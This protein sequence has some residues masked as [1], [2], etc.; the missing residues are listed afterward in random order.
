MADHPRV[1]EVTSLSNA[2]VKELRALH[3]RKGRRESG[4]FLAEGARTALEA[5]DN[6]RAPEILVYH[7]E[8]RERDVVRRLRKACLE[9]GGECLEVDDAVLAKIAKKDNPQSVV[10]AFRWTRRGFDVI[11]P[12]T[13]RVFVAL[14]RVR[15][16]GNLGTIVRTA[17]AVGAG[18]VLLVGE[19]CDPASVEAVRASMG[20]IFAVPLFEGSEADVLALAARWPGSVVGTA[21]P[22]STHYRRAA[23]RRP[24]LLVMGNEQ[25][26][27]T[28]AIAAACTDLVR[29]PMQGRA[30]SLNLAIATAVA[31]YG[32]AE[33]EDTALG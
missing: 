12:T 7:R 22:A 1:R 11:D 31:L 27:V 25:A 10:A 29:I 23:L 15:D 13:A 19:T 6:G 21:L 18:G 30:D 32:I 14:D 17:D 3:D 9:A 20:S 4:L 33:P 26:G 16:P 5:L 8:G 2:T 28:D 24:I